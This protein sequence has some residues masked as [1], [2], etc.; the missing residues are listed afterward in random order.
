MIEPPASDL[1]A[2]SAYLRIC[3]EIDKE[4]DKTKLKI[5]QAA[6]RLRPVFERLNLPHNKAAIQ[7]RAAFYT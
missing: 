2:L 7:K 1:D 5:R 6:A 3:P 4:L